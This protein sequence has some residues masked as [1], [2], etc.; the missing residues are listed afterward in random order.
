MRKDG[1]CERVDATCAWALATSSRLTSPPA[2]FLWVTSAVCTWTVEVLHRDVDLPLEL[3]QVGVIER[4]FGDERDEDVA[5]VFD[6]GFFVGIESFHV[7]PDAAEDVDFPGRIEAGP[8][9]V[10]ARFG[11]PPT[12][13][14]IGVPSGSVTVRPPMSASPGPETLWR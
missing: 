6:G 7:T 14:V 12:P 8:E 1:I 3:P 13:V 9:Q 10:A 2:D 11:R 5:P 4:H